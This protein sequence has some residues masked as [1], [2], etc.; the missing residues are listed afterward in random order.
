MSSGAQGPPFLVHHIVTILHDIVDCHVY[1]RI[2]VRT[3]TPILQMRQL[4]D[5][6]WKNLKSL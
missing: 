2:D 4:R 6:R 3:S 1:S 5:E